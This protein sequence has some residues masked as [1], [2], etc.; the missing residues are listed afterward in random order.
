MQAWEAV[1]TDWEEDDILL[2]SDMNRIEGNLKHLKEVPSDDFDLIGRTGRGWFTSAETITHFYVA[3]RLPARSSLYL[4]EA[5]KC[6]PNPD[7][8][9]KYLGLY[10]SSIVTYPANSN[11]V[12]YTAPDNDPLVRWL[13]AKTGRTFI[14]NYYY[15]DLGLKLVTNPLYEPAYL[16]FIGKSFAV[17]QA[18]TSPEDTMYMRFHIGYDDI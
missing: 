11:L 2:V 14:E 17:A 16:S 1:K 12:W 3:K 8:D 13:S 9:Y 10:I 5:S 15:E 7:G 18:R 4:R 6:F